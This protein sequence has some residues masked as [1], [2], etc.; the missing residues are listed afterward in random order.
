MNDMRKALERFLETSTPEQLRAELTKGNRPFFQTL[1]DSVLDLD[2]EF[3]LPASVSF[4]QGI[5]ADDGLVSGELNT[6]TPTQSENA[7][8]EEFALAA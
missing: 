8:N 6:Y 5:F 4:F 7:A 1:E 2:A 3:S